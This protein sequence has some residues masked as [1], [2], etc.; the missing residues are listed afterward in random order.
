MTQSIAV[1]TTAVLGVVLATA[2]CNSAHS[3]WAKAADEN[4]V[5]AYENF[6]SAHPR[7]EHA[8]EAQA[9][10]VRLQHDNGWHEAQQTMTNVYQ[11]QL[12]QFP[13]GSNAT[14]GTQK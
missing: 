11:A 10:L 2:G 6:L 4:T 5:I 7:S 3:D 9:N 12:R 8:A 14:Q 1:A 13:Q